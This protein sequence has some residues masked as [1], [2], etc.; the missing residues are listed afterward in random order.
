[1]PPDAIQ[2]VSSG[3]RVPGSPLDYFKMELS[4]FYEVAPVLP[5]DW[6]MGSCKTLLD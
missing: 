2:M 1:M 6:C 5:W 3:I 4:C